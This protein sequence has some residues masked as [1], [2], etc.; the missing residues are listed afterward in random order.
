MC[1]FIPK[2]SYHKV[3]PSI[4]LRMTQNHT[5]N[6]FGTSYYLTIQFSNQ[7]PPPPTVKMKV[8]NKISEYISY[9]LKQKFKDYFML[10]QNMFLI[11][12]VRLISDYYEQ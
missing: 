11:E 7:I 6:N 3:K 10:L 8:L 4:V 9:N 12:N 5:N 2:N 1:Q